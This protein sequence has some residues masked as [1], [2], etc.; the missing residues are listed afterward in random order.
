MSDEDTQIIAGADTPKTRSDVQLPEQRADAVAKR[1]IA[2]RN[3]LGPDDDTAE[4]PF[5]GR[6]GGGFLNR[7]DK[8]GIG[9]LVILIVSGFAGAAMVWAGGHVADPLVQANIEN[10]RRLTE[11]DV[12]QRKALTRALEHLSSTVEAQRIDREQVMR[13]L[14]V[15]VKVLIEEIRMHRKGG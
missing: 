4:I 13:E 14:V 15:S 9:I 12:E 8:L 2:N 6:I 1:R 5:F 3:E 7:L 10:S 11:A